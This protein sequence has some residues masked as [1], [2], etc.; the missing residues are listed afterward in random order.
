MDE[1]V[2]LQ[3]YIFW[4]FYQMFLMPWEGNPIKIL[5]FHFQHGS[6]FIHMHYI[7][8]H[9]WYGKVNIWIILWWNLATL[10]EFEY[11]A[12]SAC[13]FKSDSFQGKVYKSV[14]LV[15]SFIFLKVVCTIK[16]VK[17]KLL[18]SFFTRTT[19]FWLLNCDF[20]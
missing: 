2:D 18:F 5:K 16:T 15:V 6:F 10:V 13:H 1:I 19:F 9:I 12:S 20:L 17:I 3:R 11:L 7:E 14:Y 8:L 4:H